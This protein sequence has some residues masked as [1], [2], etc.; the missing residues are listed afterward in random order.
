MRS[1]VGCRRK[2]S[3]REFVRIVRSPDGEVSLDSGGRAAGRG[4]YVCANEVC[5]KKALRGS[6]LTKALRASVN[7]SVLNDLMKSVASR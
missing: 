3:K 2:A 6:R 7:E 1:C 4:A 5:V